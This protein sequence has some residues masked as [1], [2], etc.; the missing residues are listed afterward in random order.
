[1]LGIDGRAN[2]A[3]SP[4][5]FES[6]DVV[7]YMLRVARSESASVVD[8]GMGAGSDILADTFSEVA[9]NRQP[10]IRL[11]IRRFAES[12]LR[13]EL[14]ISREAHRSIVGLAAF[15]TLLSSIGASW[16]MVGREDRD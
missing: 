6:I 2:P 11:A 16:F 8:S 3:N 15:T 9:L 5:P 1:M 7:R 10:R 14:P 4:I 12:L 13:A